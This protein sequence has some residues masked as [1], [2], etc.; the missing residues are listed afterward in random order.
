MTK[1]NQHPINLTVLLDFDGADALPDRTFEHS[2]CSLEVACCIPGAG[3][4]I[5]ARGMAEKMV[6]GKLIT[7]ELEPYFKDLVDI[8]VF[9]ESA[10]V[11]YSFRLGKIQHEIADVVEK[12]PEKAELMKSIC[13]KVL[14]MGNIICRSATD[15]E[16]LNSYPIEFRQAVPF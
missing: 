7:G 10:K 3:I 2:E 16:M 13:D 12:Q 6:N 11:N 4:L 9:T 8:T 1:S 15:S 5:Y 14:E